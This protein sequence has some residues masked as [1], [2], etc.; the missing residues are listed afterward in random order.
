MQ[1]DYKYNYDDIDLPL[2]LSSTKKVR[3]PFY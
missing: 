3:K 1:Y 2:I